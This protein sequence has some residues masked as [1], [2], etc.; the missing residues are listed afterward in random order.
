MIKLNLGCGDNYLAGY[1]NVDLYNDK[2]DIKD[3]ISSL[4]NVM[5]NC[6][7]GQDTVDEIYS[8]HSLMCV[9]ETMILGTLKHW[10]VLLKNGGKLIIETTD[11][12]KQMLEYSND[13]ASAE[14][15]MHSL[16]GDN[17][18]D[19]AGLRYQF[20]FYLLKKWLERAGFKNITKIE[21]PKYS[22]HNKEFNL[23]VE[24]TK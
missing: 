19:G 13:R 24:A 12:E 22:K 11:F 20:D 5:V 4:V 14:I 1:V 18:Q 10:N 21:Q 8:S 7:L 16:F 15:V 3:D 23:C 6:N 2:A 17:I 9:P